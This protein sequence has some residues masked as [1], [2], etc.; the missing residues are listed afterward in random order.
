MMMMIMI[1]MMTM[2]R[3]GIQAKSPASG[4]GCGHP[5]EVFR[6][7]ARISTELID[8]GIRA[9]IWNPSYDLLI[10]L[11]FMFVYIRA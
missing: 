7:R 6:L 5:G 4:L 3:M 2:M 1:M 10:D 11:E 9:R 8:L